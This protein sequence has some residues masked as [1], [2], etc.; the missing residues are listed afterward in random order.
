MLTLNLRPN[1]KIRITDFKP[2]SL[3]LSKKQLLCIKNNKRLSKPLLKKKQN[4]NRNHRN[5]LKLRPKVLIKVPSSKKNK[6]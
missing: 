6:G 2:N 3:Q 4:S 5:L 1:M